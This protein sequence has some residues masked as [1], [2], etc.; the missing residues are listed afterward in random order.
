MCCEGGVVYEA[1]VLDPSCLTAEPNRQSAGTGCTLEGTGIRN[2][3]QDCSHWCD[4]KSKMKVTLLLFNTNS[5]T[6][7]AQF[8]L[9]YIRRSLPRQP[10]LQ[11][12]QSLSFL[13]IKH[14]P[15]YSLWLSRRCA[16]MG[17]LGGESGGENDQRR[18]HLPS[19]FA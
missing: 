11:I 13:I 7:P 12:S 5:P 15:S 8:E 9:I 6:K 19:G 14:P 18:L 4:S 17:S 2:F 10:I 3:S 16:S 1:T